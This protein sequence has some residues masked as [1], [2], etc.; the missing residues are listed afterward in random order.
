MRRVF[1]AIRAVCSRSVCERGLGSF[2]GAARGVVLSSFVLGASLTLST[3]ARS[4]VQCDEAAESI[5]RAA[6]EGQVNPVGR[7]DAVF[8]V[9]ALREY[10]DRWA[11]VSRGTSLYGD[12]EV[13]AGCGITVFNEQI[14][15]DIFFN[16]PSFSYPAG[17]FNP[18]FEFYNDMNKQKVSAEAAYA[19]L[20]I[21]DYARFAARDASV[22][23]CSMWEIL[24]RQRAGSCRN[25]GVTPEFA[26]I[27]FRE[28]PRAR[29]FCQ[30]YQLGVSDC[31]REVNW[32][33]PFCKIVVG[34]RDRI[35]NIDSCDFSARRKRI[36]G[37]RSYPVLR[38]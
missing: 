34:I 8:K 14:Y 11:E 12:S 4:A 32:I 23:G 10:Y 22:Q 19:R 28:L 37:A 7:S 21:E 24:Y 26:G 30:R 17:G 31:I 1:G 15:Q 3:A 5:S 35:F 9:R 33:M 2:E 18:Y 20:M 25:Q 27:Y 16:V 29:R 13:G 6:S 36:V 38:R